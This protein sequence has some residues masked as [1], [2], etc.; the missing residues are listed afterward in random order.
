MTSSVLPSP[1]FVPSSWVHGG[2]ETVQD[3]AQGSVPRKGLGTALVLPDRY[4]WCE[5]YPPKIKILRRG[6]HCSLLPCHSFP[7]LR[8]SLLECHIKVKP[9]TYFSSNNTVHLL[10]TLQCTECIDIFCLILT[11]HLWGEWGRYYPDEWKWWNWA[12]RSGMTSK[13][14]LWGEAQI[15]W[16]REGKSFCSAMPTWVLDE[17]RNKMWIY[18]K[19]KLL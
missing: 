19:C 3:L 8:L 15:F 12:Q 7:A 14:Q 6:Q 2:Q 16:F 13:K 17:S 4:S 9:V 1:P 10:R 18:L 11:T 5:F